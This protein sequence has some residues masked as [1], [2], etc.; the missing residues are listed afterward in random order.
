MGQA[1]GIGRPVPRGRAAGGDMEHSSP[2]GLARGIG[3]C[4]KHKHLSSD[5]TFSVTSRFVAFL[6]LRQRAQ[7]GEFDPLIESF[8]R[9]SSPWAAF[10]R[11]APEGQTRG[12]GRPVPRG[13]AAGGDMEHSSPDGLARGIS[14]CEKHK[15]LCS[16]FSF[17]VTSRFVE[18]PMLGQLAKAEEFDP[19]IESFARSSS[20]WAAFRR[21]A[22]EGQARG[23]GRPVPRGRAAGGDMEHS[24]H[25]GLARSIGR[26]EKTQTPILRFYFLCYFAVCLISHVEAASKS[27]GV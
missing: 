24:S 20:P 11:P 6:I 2:D 21:P 27:G 8:D 22:P 18:F 13:R 3:R 19:L 16:D 1:R 25:D 14:R 17:C 12:I 9:S 7:A 10:R 4:E 5:F 15:H 23:I 26:C